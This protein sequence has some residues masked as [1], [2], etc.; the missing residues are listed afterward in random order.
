MFHG[1]LWRGDLPD[2]FIGLDARFGCWHPGLVAAALVELEDRPGFPGL[3]D[4][5]KVGD[6]VLDTFATGHRCCL[7]LAVGG[8]DSA[9]APANR[10]CARVLEPLRVM[11]HE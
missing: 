11:K 8:L 2:P 6:A 3:V 10:A 1:A 7:V 9:D 4:S 5:R